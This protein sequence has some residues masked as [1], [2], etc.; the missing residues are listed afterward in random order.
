MRLNMEKVRKGKRKMKIFNLGNGHTLEVEKANRGIEDDYKVTFKEDG[1][2]LYRKNMKYIVVADNG[3]T[4]IMNLDKEE[5]VVF[6][7]N[8]KEKYPENNFYVRR[9]VKR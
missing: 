2:A 9:Q 6:A 4:L 5:A 8:M 3:Q 7:M 1:K